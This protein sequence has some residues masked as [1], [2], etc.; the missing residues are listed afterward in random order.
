[1]TKELLH[2]MEEL[3]RQAE[4]R[5]D[6]AVDDA[7]EWNIQDLH[8]VVH[9]LRVHQIE[10][11]MQNEELRATQQRL[12]TARDRAE[13]LQKCFTHLFNAAP[14]GYVIVNEAG[15]IQLSNA[16]LA[17]MLRVD[18]GRLT[19]TPLHKWVDAR[20]RDELLARF[21]SF[22]AKPESKRMTLRLLPWEGEPF[23]AELEGRR[24]QWGAPM[25]GECRPDGKQLLIIIHDV[26]ELVA[27][28]EAMREA[29]DV[30]E[31]ATR[32]KDKFVSLV[33]HDLR[34]PLS[35]IIGLLQFLMEEGETNLTEEQKT[36]IGTACNSSRH[37]I[38]MAEEVLNLSRLN[39]GLLSVRQRFFDARM[40]VDDCLLKLQ[41]LSRQKGLEVVNSVPEGTRF[42]AD[43][44]LYGEV[45]QNLVSNA[46]KFS[47][48]GKSVVVRTRTDQ[49]GVLV[50]EDQGVGIPQDMLSGLFDPAIKTSRPGTSGETGSGFALPFCASIMESHGGDLAVQSEEGVGTRFTVTLP[51][52]A[53][54]IL[55]VDDDPEL[56]ALLR[57]HLE[58]LGSCTLFEALDGQTALDLARDFPPDVVLCDVYMP[59]LDGFGFLRRLRED[60]QTHAIPVIMITADESV[61]TQEKLLRQGAFDVVQK[62]VCAEELIPRVRRVIW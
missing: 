46:I 62:P 47:H 22:Y 8:Q 54:R 35:S 9:E 29:R 32:I 57:M 11:E 48:P 6:R 21:P 13:S 49:P 43:P 4:R 36:L 53:P 31:R 27:T 18:T 41:F 20:D 45:I 33:A 38:R 25:S 14:S 3:R 50:V 55:L 17:D 12:I 2:E 28:R 1:M 34:S 5:L 58:R 59:V 56:L 19:G 30:A 39:T 10:L 23:Y 42:Y 7:G 61:E 15:M 16:T 24:S 37:L 44:V 40:V 51:H 52:V 60:P 26:S